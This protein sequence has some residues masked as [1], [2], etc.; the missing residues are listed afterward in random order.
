[1][2]EGDSSGRSAHLLNCY[3]RGVGEI[4]MKIQKQQYILAVLAA[5]LAFALSACGSRDSGIVM[6]RRGTGARTVKAEMTAQKKRLQWKPAST[7]F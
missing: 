3:D 6:E 4:S 7:S 2:T 5:F 1:M